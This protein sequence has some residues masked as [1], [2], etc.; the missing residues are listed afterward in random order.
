MM[1]S[2]AFNVD[3]QDGKSLLPFWYDGKPP[4]VNVASA[5]DTTHCTLT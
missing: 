1:Y 4:R 2:F 5:D 3:L